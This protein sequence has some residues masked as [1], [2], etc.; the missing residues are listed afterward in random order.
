MF[1]TPPNPSTY[2]PIV[3]QVVRQVPHGVVS[4]YGQIASIIPPPEGV[5]AEDY[6]RLGAQWVGKA[7]NAISFP[8]IDGKPN[9][10]P[11]PWWRIINS[12]GGISMP[13]GSKAA[14]EQRRLL[15]AENVTFDIKEQVNLNQFGWEGPPQDW[16][17]AHG[18]V[19]PKSLRKPNTPTQ[20]TLF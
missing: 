10:P 18:F 6:R 16:L 15:E 17:D 1:N 8:E 13:A 5:K 20:P 4:T 9:Q 12:K 2:N 19:K 7:L 3:W 11:I 14:A